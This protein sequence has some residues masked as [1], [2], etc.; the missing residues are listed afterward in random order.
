[1]KVLMVTERFI[2]IWGGAE[3]QLRQLAQGLSQKN[4]QVEIVT[5][6]W[7]DDLPALET[8]DGI[9][10]FRVG[11]SGTTK[12]KTVLFSLSLIR[13]L[14]S[15]REQYDVFHSHGAVNLGALC[16]LSTLFSGT[17]NVAK[18]ATAG[19]FSEV[20]RKPLGNIL[21]RLFNTSDAVICMTNEIYA[22][23]RDNQTP[24]TIIHKIPNGIDDVRFCPP[25]DEKKRLVRQKMGISV[26]QP[27]VLFCGRLVQRKGLDTL[28]DAWSLI[29]R[30]RSNP[31][32]LI[33]GSGKGQ[34]DSVESQL[35][36]KVANLGIENIEFCGDTVE[37]EIY[38]RAADI[39]VLPSL[40]EGLP[41]ALL[42]AMSTGL[43]VIATRIGG[44]IDIVEDAKQGLLFAPGD[45][46]ALSE[47]LVCF[48]ERA[49]LRQKLG[50]AARTLARE[51]Y[52]AS[53][54]ADKYLE[55]YR[56]ITHKA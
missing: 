1:M 12:W 6:R 22:E 26:D 19:K 10:V 46:R 3:N 35:R 24:L 49:D 54:I 28:I 34:P 11:R 18:I 2:P 25:S 20:T 41:N 44:I 53:V 36:E 51:R 56:R 16:R 40:Q 48:L 42:E 50:A 17:K 39:F 30:H 47:K 32:L 43:A 33:V 31:L 15:R 38:L 29:Q 4:C 7:R 5:R 13:F 52:S 55:L 9:Q 8:I 37:P 45:S 27:V 21:K 23:L 14:L